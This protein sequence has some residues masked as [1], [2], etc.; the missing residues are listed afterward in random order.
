M[1]YT[2]SFFLLCCF[3]QC[4]LLH[5]AEPSVRFDIR[6]LCVDANEGVAVTD[7]DGDGAIDVVAGRSW[8]RNPDF[9][10]RPLRIIPDWNGYVE[11]NGEFIVDVNGDGR[12]D[13]VAGSF[14]PT[15]IQWFENPGQNLYAWGNTGK[16]TI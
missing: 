5:G 2:T 16:H 6:P 8:Y 11:S 7:V 4:G 12:P 10:P 15:K 9:S 14:L 3:S 13:V 1:R